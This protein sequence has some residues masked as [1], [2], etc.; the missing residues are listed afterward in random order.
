MSNFYEFIVANI[1]SFDI[2]TKLPDPKNGW[3][4]VLFK[5]PS[6]DGGTVSVLMGEVINGEIT[7]T[8]A[9]FTLTTYELL[10]LCAQVFKA[11]GDYDDQNIPD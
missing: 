9:L 7:N 3:D 4:V 1:Q 2:V 11:W 10:A 8:H 5:E 6:Q